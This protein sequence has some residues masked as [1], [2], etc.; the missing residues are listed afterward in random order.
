MKIHFEPQVIDAIAQRVIELLKLHL[1]VKEEPR[2]VPPPKSKGHYMTDTQLAEYLQ[3]SKGTIIWQKMVK[4]NYLE[5]FV[6]YL[7]PKAILAAFPN[8]ARRLFYAGDS[9]RLL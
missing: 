1:A 8:G 6:K 2:V 3:I 4:G 9:Q 7:S 5:E